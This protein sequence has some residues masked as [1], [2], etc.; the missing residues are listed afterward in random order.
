M[1]FDEFKDLMI[2]RG[3]TILDVY[4][5]LAD[6]VKSHESSRVLVDR[7]NHYL[8]RSVYFASYDV[9]RFTKMLTLNGDKM[10][11]RRFAC[12][13]GDAFKFLLEKKRIEYYYPTSMD[14]IYE[15]MLSDLWLNLDLSADWWSD[16]LNS[17]LEDI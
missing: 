15:S 12:K 7:F 9:R 2:C 14:N 13:V 17:V 16:D 5:T 4:L 1:K 10:I 11:E 8:E 6:F 3:Y